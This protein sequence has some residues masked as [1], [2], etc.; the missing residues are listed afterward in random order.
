LIPDSAK[1]LT[2]QSQDEIKPAESPL[3]A[4]AAEPAEAPAPA[5]AAAPVVIAQNTPP[6]APATR[7][8]DIAQPN[9]PAVSSN[10]KSTDDTTLPQTASYLP[11]IGAIGLGSLAAGIL[12]ASVRRYYSL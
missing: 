9:P 12:L 6:P 3:A 11:L 5:A 7:S 4:N 1:A 10:V 8:D 2:V